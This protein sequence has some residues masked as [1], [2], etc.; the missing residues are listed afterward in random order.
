MH[1][2]I[3]TGTAGDGATTLPPPLDCETAALI[4]QVLLPIFDAAPDW[5]S[6]SRA[7]SRKGYSVG[8][9]QGRMVILDDTTGSALCTGRDGGTP[10]RT[11]AQR[12]GRP[13]L[14]LHRDGRSAELAHRE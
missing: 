6:L 4:R 14:K 10:L 11:L 5:Q 3:Q 2:Q 9:R 12:L 8:F 1:F 13:A 7:L